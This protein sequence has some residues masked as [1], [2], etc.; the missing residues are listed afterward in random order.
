MISIYDI[1]MKPL[2]KRGITKARRELIPM[3]YGNV[4]EI[5]AG[6]GVNIK[7]YNMPLISK[8]TLSDVALSKKVKDI[9]SKDIF[10][11][12]LNVEALPFDDNTFDVVIH[13]LVF[14]SV[15][16]VSKGLAEI[17]RVLKPDGKLLFIEH[18]LPKRIGLKRFFKFINPA[19]RRIA[20]GCNLTREFED[21]L[22]KQGFVFDTPTRFMKSA[23]I[24]GVAKTEQRNT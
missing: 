13:T 16:D 20:S 6:T 14:C 5:G 2:E 8:L 21:S 17:K 11:T 4:L 23:F 19:W 15:T 7:Y 22:S 10:L 12:E 24:S 1:F 9:A 18:V 3:A